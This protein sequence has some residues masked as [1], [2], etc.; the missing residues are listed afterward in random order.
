MSALDRIVPASA[1]RWGRLTR[2]PAEVLAAIGRNSVVVALGTG[3]VRV[4]RSMCQDAGLDF[5]ALKAAET[6]PGPFT[7]ENR[8]AWRREFHLG[9]DHSPEDF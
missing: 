1:L 7:A 6:Q 4:T 8:D 5:D 9:L 3:K 2:G